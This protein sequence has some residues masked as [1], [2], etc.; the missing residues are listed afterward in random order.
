M[1]ILITGISGFIGSSIAL[2]LN[3]KFDVYGIS[4]QK[5]TKKNEFFLDLLD[6]D[7]CCK[8][9]DKNNFDIIIHLASIMASKNTTDDFSLMDNNLLMTK[10]LIHSLR[11]KESGY[12]INFS[13]SAV[14]PNLTGIF[15]EESKIDSSKNSDCLYGLSKFN[16]EILFNYFLK[17]Y[18]ILNLRLGYVYGKNMNQ[19]RIHKVFENEIKTKNK[20]TI[21]GNGDRMFPQ[22]SIEYLS[23]ILVE[24]I[25]NRLEGTYNLAEENISLINLAKKYI[26]LYGDKKSKILFNKHYNNNSKFEMDLDKLNIKLNI[27]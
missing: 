1:K 21:W 3:K 18:K 24:I 9:F 20:I 27:K 5:S 22:L 6:L 11:N 7:S 13:S 14:Y 26:K 10:N 16:N 17:N 12:L 4:N 25:D 8:Y 15:H 23:K 2:E 19:S